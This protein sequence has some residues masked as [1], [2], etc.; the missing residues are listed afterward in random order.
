[1]IFD[2][3]TPS[4]L[5]KFQLQFL[6]CPMKCFD[7]LPL[8]DI[9]VC[10]MSTKLIFATHNLNKLR[11]IEL[12]MP[13]NLNLLSLTDL[14]FHDE[15]PENFD[16]L[17]GNAQSK[18]TQIQNLFGMDCF[19]DDTGL[20]V[21]ALDGQPGVYSAR[22]AGPNADSQANIQKL[23]RVMEGISNRKA[24][25]RT[26][27]A[28]TEGTNTLFFEGIVNGEILKAPSGMGGFGYDSVFKPYGFDDSFATF[29]AEEKNKVSHRGVA[30]RKLI[31]HLSK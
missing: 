24:R 23:L 10:Y 2:K 3:T 7:T 21:E 16:T 14:N 11:E 17:E 12:M 4:I 5:L 22:Y 28:L 26:V 31:S 15:I 27:I 8:S 19:A 29:T 9:K 13:G 25:F 1:M 20:E 18:A 30:F 6:I